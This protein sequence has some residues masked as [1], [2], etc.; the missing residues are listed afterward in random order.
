[1]RVRLACSLLT[2]CV[3]AGPAAAGDAYELRKLL[4]RDAVVGERIRTVEEETRKQ[5]MGPR[6]AEERPAATFV[7]EVQAVGK[8]GEATRTLRT[9]ESFRDPQGAEVPVAGVKVLLTRDEATGQHAVAPAEG[10]APV[11]PVLQKGL[12]GDVAGKNERA[13]K[14]YTDD[15]LGRVMLPEEAKAVGDTWSNDVAE[16]V[17]MIGFELEDVDLA[18]SSSEGV[19]DGVEEADGRSWIKFHVTLKL[20]LKRLPNSGGQPLPSPCPMDTTMAFRLPATGDAP[21]GESHMTQHIELALQ[22]P[23]GQAMNMTIDMEKVERR[24]LLK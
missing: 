16:M 21:D 4:D 11:P 18:A 13:A 22:G 24:T 1:M 6:K 15:D 19:V 17:K 9:Y 5:V 3:S 10:S 12:E 23:Q 8:D 20:I 2:L 14:G 7:D